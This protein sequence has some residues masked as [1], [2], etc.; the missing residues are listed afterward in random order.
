VALLLCAGRKRSE[1]AAQLTISARTVDVH[2]T[3]IYRKTG[4]ASHVELALAVGRTA[5]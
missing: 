1:I 5:L 4:V 2:I 3:R